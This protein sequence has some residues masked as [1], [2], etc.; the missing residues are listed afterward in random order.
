MPSVYDVILAIN[1]AQVSF[2]LASKMNWLPNLFR[3]RIME[4]PVAEE[5]LSRGFARTSVHPPKSFSGHIKDWTARKTSTRSIFGLMGL[6]EV[7]DDR[8]HAEINPAKNTTAYHLL[9][10]AVVDGVASSIFSP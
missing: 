10:Q 3:E 5:Q 6:L 7:I 2:T 4:Q 1:L 8:Q 9:T